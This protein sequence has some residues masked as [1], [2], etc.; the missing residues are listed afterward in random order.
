M[1][2]KIQY[3]NS[4]T[5]NRLK[6]FQTEKKTY[7]KHFMIF[8]TCF[9]A[10]DRKLLFI[11]ISQEGK[12]TPSNPMITD[13]RFQKDVLFSPRACLGGRKICNPITTAKPII[14]AAFGNSGAIKPYF[15]KN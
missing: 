13:T 8:M 11:M 14:I 15:A 10:Y 2:E 5:E 3:S 12:N 7:P 4:S 6:G 9:F 1:L